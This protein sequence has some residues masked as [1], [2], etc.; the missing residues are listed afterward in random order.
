MFI[1]DVYL[2]ELSCHF[3]VE[4]NRSNIDKLCEKD[5]KSVRKQLFNTIGEKL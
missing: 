2:I 5:N 1:F 4:D 3:D